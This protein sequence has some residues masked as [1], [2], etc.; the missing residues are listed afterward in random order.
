MDI[1]AAIIAYL[2]ERLEGVKVYADVPEEKPDKFVTVE[3]TG[4]NMENRL[5]HPRVAIQAWATRRYVASA[6][7][8]DVDRFMCDMP[9]YVEDVM[10]CSR[11][12]TYNWPDPDSRMPRYQGIYLLTTAY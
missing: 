7:M 9:L 8:A 6:L 10:G 4:G 12:T 2:T 1:E 11:D 5:D 3:R